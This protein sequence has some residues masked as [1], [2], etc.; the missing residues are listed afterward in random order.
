MAIEI[1]VESS[2]DTD[3]GEGRTVEVSVSERD[4]PWE[5]PWENSCWF[6]G[7]DLE[8]LK[9]YLCQLI[10]EKAARFSGRDRRECLRCRKITRAESRAPDF[11]CAACRAI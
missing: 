5:D 9:R 11:Y 10:E 7:G 1:R 2:W 6:A 3:D 8:K 4:H